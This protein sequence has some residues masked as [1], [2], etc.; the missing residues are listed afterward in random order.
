MSILVT[1]VSRNIPK[2]TYRMTQDL[3]LVLFPPLPHHVVLNPTENLLIVS[4][5][6]DCFFLTERH[7]I[8][9]LPNIVVQAKAM[10]RYQVCVN[11]RLISLRISSSW[12]A[13]TRV[14]I[15]PSPCCSMKAGE[16]PGTR[17]F[18]LKDNSF[19][20]ITWAI[21]MNTAGPILCPNKITPIP[22]LTS[23]EFSVVCIAACGPWKPIPPLKP[24][25]PENRM[26]LVRDNWMLYVVIRPAAIGMQTEAKIM[27]GA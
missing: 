2:S 16:I 27:K 1:S 4:L 10:G 24:T 17:L 22:R 26:I 21:A 7:S 6:H 23:A 15:S 19:V 12:L 14:F 9:R 20:K 5:P 3:I 13:G 8:K 18:R 11:P 25:N